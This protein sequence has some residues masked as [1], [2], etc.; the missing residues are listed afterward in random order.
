M[1]S[2]LLQEGPEHLTRILR[3]MIEWLERNEYR[4]VSQLK[5]SISQQ[6]AIDPAAFERANYISVLDSYSHPR[7]VLR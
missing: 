7:G 2:A 3:E 4:S 1:C 5:G 6:H